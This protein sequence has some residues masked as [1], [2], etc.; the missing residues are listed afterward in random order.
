MLTAHNSS[1]QRVCLAD[2]RI[3]TKVKELRKVED[4]FCPECGCRLVLK[5]GDKKAWHFAHEHRSSCS[6]Y[7]RETLYHL[8]GKKQIYEWLKR[9]DISPEIEPFDPICRQRPDVGFCWNKKKYVVEYQCSPIPETLF[10]KRTNVFFENDYYP[11][12]ILGGNQLKRLKNNVVSLSAFH[13]LFTHLL[14][15]Q[16]VLIV[17]CPVTKQLIIL[18]QLV[19]ISTRKFLCSFYINTL[20][21]LK[22]SSFLPDLSIKQPFILNWVLE[23]K[24]FK[25]RLS[26]GPGAYNNCF[27][28][29]LYQN[30]LNIHLLPPQL[31]VPVKN[32]LLIE[33]PPLI[34]QTFLFIDVFQHHKAGQLISLSSLIEAFSKRVRKKEILLRRL[35]LVKTRN[36]GEAVLSYMEILTILGYFK[37]VNNSMFQLKK[38]ITISGSIPEKIKMERLFYNQ[39][40]LQIETAYHSTK[41]FY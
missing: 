36:P 16:E 29:T 1:G 18:H 15:G 28:R 14:R 31:G 9:W 35:P 25:D 38:P 13:L 3:R 26:T 4:F 37:L 22:P 11:I 27:L 23:L 20:E 19:P 41:S 10:L 12:W 8:S 32:S 17:Y 2:E 7:K 40:G 34:W 39:F 24:R 21:Y 30:R 33:T 5:L 6:D